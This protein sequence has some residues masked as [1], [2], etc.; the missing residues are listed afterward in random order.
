MYK[1]ILI[2]HD[3]SEPSQYALEWAI[4]A[5]NYFTSDIDVLHVIDSGLMRNVAGLTEIPKEA[6]SVIQKEIEQDVTRYLELGHKR[7]KSINIQVIWGHPSSSILSILKEKSYDLVV[8]GTHGRT[9]IKHLALG[10]LAEKIVRHAPT[11]VLVAKRHPPETAGR[12][13]VPIDFS[14]FSEEALKNAMPLAKLMSA[15]IDLLHVVSTADVLLLDPS[16]LLIQLDMKALKSKALDRLGEIASKYTEADINLHVE[17]GVPAESIVRVADMMKS[18]L[19]VIPTH[20]LTGMHHLL[21]GSISEQ[22]VRYAH[23]DVLSFCPQRY[24]GERLQ[25]AA[26]LSETA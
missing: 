13:L 4:N 14:E 19:I 8:M 10:S 22:V 1:N 15:S 5:G 3:L 17:V 23:C 18:G 24:V 21:M 25:T 2:L 26:K 7:H 9:G 16:R 20:G 11:P 12:I 6:F